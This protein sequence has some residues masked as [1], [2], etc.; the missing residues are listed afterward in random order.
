MMLA[1]ELCKVQVFQV[2]R[3][4]HRHSA[5]SPLMIMAK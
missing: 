3:A 1:Q 4:F 5:P 2:V